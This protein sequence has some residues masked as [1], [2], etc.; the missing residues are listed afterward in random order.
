VEPRLAR[1][2]VGFVLADGKAILQ[3]AGFL[4]P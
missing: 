4:T 3:A 1:E 2:F